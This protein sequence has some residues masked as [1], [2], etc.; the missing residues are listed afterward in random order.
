M[1]QHASEQNS[2]E[3][4][5]F[6]YVAMKNEDVD[7]DYDVL[8][9]FFQAFEGHY[10]QTVGENFE[11]F[12]SNIH[13]HLEQAMPKSEPDCS[14]SDF[15][16]DDDKHFIGQLGVALMYL[17]YSQKLFNQG[18]TVLHVLH[19]FSINYSMYT[20]ECGVQQRPLTPCEVALT[21]A[22]ICLNQSQP[23]YSSA[24]EVLRGTN[25]ACAANG[26]ILT[27][28]ET[29]WRRRVF[30]SLCEYFLSSKEF[31]LTIELL[32][33]VGDVEVFGIAE[34]KALYNQLL[35]GLISNKRLDDVTEL[36]K[37]MEEK[38]I[39]WE[40]SLVRALV[41]GFGEAGIARQAKFFFKKGVYTGVYPNSFR[42]DNP[43][44][45]TVGISLSAL[46]CQFYIERHL[47]S[48]SEFIKRQAFSSGGDPLDD[49]YYSPL[50]VVVKSDEVPNLYTRDRYMRHDEVIRVMRE[51]VSTVLTDD[52]NPPLSCAAE[53]KDE[54]RRRKHIVL[55]SY[56]RLSHKLENILGNNK[57]PRRYNGQDLYLEHFT[58]F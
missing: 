41:D 34:V 4:L 16:D 29:V 32:D 19:N 52:F 7:T 58:V 27:S 22:D 31:D 50:R 11:K 42:E 24:L 17:T 10:V 15:L 38:H 6:V 39:S 30:V 40:P 12:G 47:H 54:V 5:G 51:K 57:F 33:K 26:T 1:F 53:G 46:E 25:Y 2:W 45:V 20:G 8:Q 28:E 37:I 48:L 9:A 36:L 43:W 23:L 13:H 18:Y 14:P 49:K 56:L 21:A 44:T 3:D 55:S 35:H